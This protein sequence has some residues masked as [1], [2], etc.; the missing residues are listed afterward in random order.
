MPSTTE[1]RNRDAH[2]NS[3]TYTFPAD[4][5]H[6]VL[7][8]FTATG[9]KAVIRGGATIS[10]D[11]EVG[12]RDL[13]VGI[14]FPQGPN[15]RPFSIATAKY[16][17]LESLVREQVMSDFGVSDVFGVERTTDYINQNTGNAIQFGRISRAGR[18]AK[19][20]KAA[21]A[22]AEADARGYS[23]RFAIVKHPH[24]GYMGVTALELAVLG[25]PEVEGWDFLSDGE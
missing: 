1:G 10:G 15:G 8:G 17:A 21:A 7:R 6:E 14:V 18:D 13:E 9:G 23:T 20:S 22:E 25:L 3:I 16:P 2:M 24:H 19:C 4:F 12:F 11:F 5:R